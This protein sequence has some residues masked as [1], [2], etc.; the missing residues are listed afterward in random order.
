MAHLRVAIQVCTLMFF[1]KLRF[2]VWKGG[3][4]EGGGG[5]ILLR[6]LDFTSKITES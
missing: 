4:V 5:G 1:F 3:G 6:R 2:D